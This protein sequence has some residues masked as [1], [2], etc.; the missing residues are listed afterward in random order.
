[1]CINCVYNKNGKEK[2]LFV[3]NVDNKA[4]LLRGYY[5]LNLII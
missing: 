1:M 2:F 3:D 5:Y 4:V